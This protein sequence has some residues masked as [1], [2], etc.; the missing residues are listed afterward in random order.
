M[1]DRDDR[2]DPPADPES[3]IGIPFTE[4]AAATTRIQKEAA[5]AADLGLGVP[6]ANA[7]GGSKPKWGSFLLAYIQFRAGPAAVPVAAVSAAT[8]KAAATTNGPP[9]AAAAER[10][11]AAQPIMH[12]AATSSQESQHKQQQQP[13]GPLRRLQPRRF[14]WP[15]PPPEPRRFTWPPP[16]SGTKEMQPHPPPYPP[17]PQLPVPGTKE[18]PP[19]KL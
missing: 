5:A 4:S 12:P 6:A 3:G 18:R 17:P 13:Y 11:Q 16:L 2:R 19:Q 7:I 10:A 15:P 8:P 9:P 14:T 1:A